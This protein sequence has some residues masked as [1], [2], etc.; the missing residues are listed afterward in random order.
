MNMALTR[1]STKCPELV[2]NDAK[3]RS[4]HIKHQDQKLNIP[5]IFHLL[6]NRDKVYVL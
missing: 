2:R 5:N 1:Q 6:H 3:K 4:M